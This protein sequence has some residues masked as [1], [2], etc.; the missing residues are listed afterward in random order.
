MS[1]GRQQEHTE[2]QGGALLSRAELLALQPP[3]LR[4]RVSGSLSR[5]AGLTCR[6]SWG[7][8]GAGGRVWVWREGGC[9]GAVRSPRRCPKPKPSYLLTG[10]FRDSQCLVF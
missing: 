8:G 7:M 2:G 5:G 9:V 3:V 4:A 1:G 6:H 10:T